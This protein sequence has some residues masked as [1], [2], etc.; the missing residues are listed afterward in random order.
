[1]TDWFHRNH[2]KA[3]IKLSFDFGTVATTSGC[4][5][6]CSEAAKRRVELLKLISEPSLPCDTIL[7][8]LNHY[9]Q[10]LMGFIVAP[11]NKTS[12][13][14]LRSLIYVKWCNSIKPKGEPIV[15][16]DSIFEL[17][18]II[19][20]VALWYT[21]HAAKVVSTA[22]V[23]EDDA[24]DAHLSLR[25]AAGLFSLL[26]TKYIHE[27]TE[28][29]PN[30]DL[31][32]NILD[33][34]INQSLAEAQEITVARAIELKHKPHL[35]AGLANE[36]AKF[37]EKCGLSLTQC[38][39]KVVGKWK[40]YSEFKQFCYEAYAYIFY[41]SD[42]LIKEKAGQAIAVLR[43]ASVSYNKAVRASHEYTKVEGVSLS[44]KAPDH[45]FFRRLPGL[46]ERTSSRCEVDN[47]LIFH[48]KVPTVAPVLE[49]KA[50]HGIVT[51]KE[52]ELNFELDPRWK[53]SYIEFDTSKIIDN[54][55]QDSENS[56]NRKQSGF[57][58]TPVEPICEVPIYSTDKDPNNVSG[59]VIS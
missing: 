17:Y 22:N 2:L 4:R 1:M 16:S 24:K 45:C 52:P 33:A 42:L 51:P 36:T 34:Y 41:G 54:S 7:T 29:V 55:S 39:S 44:T 56:K 10:L 9:L 14:K 19:F 35:I 48:Q 15:R 21:K 49:A 38:N 46:I 8:S 18:S 31:D 50:E 13:S 40:K 53:V 43:E 27:F 3:T 58:N 23:S 47:G 26:R 32:L 11:D 5:I 57:K 12:Y 30:S 59:C 6:L 20:N 37:Y 28:F 25:T